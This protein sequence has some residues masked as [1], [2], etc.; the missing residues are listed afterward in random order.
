MTTLYVRDGEEFREACTQDVLDRANALITQRF[1]TG[2]PVMGSPS[3]TRE[4]LRLKM[5]ALE[6]EIFAALFLDSRNRLIEYVELF[7]G[8]INGALYLAM[9]LSIALKCL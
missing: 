6:H 8:T 9:R 7:R 5:A 1:R 3:R 4:F 2:A